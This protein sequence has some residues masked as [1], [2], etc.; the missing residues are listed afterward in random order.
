[1]LQPLDSL[2]EIEWNSLLA[3]KPEVLEVN[4][5]YE[6]IVVTSIF[7]RKWKYKVSHYDN[8]HEKA[9]AIIS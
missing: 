1:M 6:F 5:T 2:V 9:L 4:I 3:T 7:A 8:F